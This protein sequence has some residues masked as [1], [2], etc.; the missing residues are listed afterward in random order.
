MHFSGIASLKGNRSIVEKCHAIYMVPR[1]MLREENKMLTE[2]E[3]NVLRTIRQP[4]RITE[5]LRYWILKGQILRI[6]GSGSSLRKTTVAF[7]F[8]GTWGL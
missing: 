3:K 7:I 8:P 5:P 6:T 1:K 4:C 2:R